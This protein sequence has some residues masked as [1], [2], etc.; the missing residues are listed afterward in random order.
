MYR[1]IPI[2]TIY[3]WS[4]TRARNF[5]HVSRTESVYTK[6][7]K[8]RGR[9]HYRVALETERL[10]RIS[11]SSS[12]A[13]SVAAMQQSD[14]EDTG[15]R[16][17][18]HLRNWQ[19]RARCSWRIYFEFGTLIVMITAVWVL[20]SLPVFFY[21]LSPVQVYTTRTSG[22][23]YIISGSLEICVHSDLCIYMSLHS[24]LP[25]YCALISRRAGLFVLFVMC[26]CRDVYTQR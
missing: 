23:I 26:L 20:L 16:K 12:E 17:K 25:S 3:R 18:G 11:V 21:Y 10:R 15:P 5:A 7:L 24:I 4:D 2:S 13:V 14:K 9:A 22:S 8:A 19:C 1:A 6:S